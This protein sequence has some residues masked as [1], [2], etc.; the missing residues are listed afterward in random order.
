MSKETGKVYGKAI[1]SP[2]ISMINMS[3]FQAALNS[4]TH[5]YASVKIG[6]NNA[7]DL[8]YL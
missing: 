2:P 5:G 1:E 3:W 8:L 4:S 6:L 7:G